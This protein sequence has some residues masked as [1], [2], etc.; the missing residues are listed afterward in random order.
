MRAI[1]FDVFEP[2]YMA[3]KHCMAPLPAVL[4]LGHSWIH[5]SAFDCSDM[6]SYIEASVSNLWH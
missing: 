2:M 6:A 4:V 5:V 1:T 3:H